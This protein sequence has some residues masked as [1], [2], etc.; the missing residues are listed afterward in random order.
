MD[1][2]RSLRLLQLVLDLLTIKEN[3]LEF[4]VIESLVATL[5]MLRQHR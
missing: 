1:T 5:I 4:L 3:V 2:T